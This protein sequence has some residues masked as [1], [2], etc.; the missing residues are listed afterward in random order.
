MRHINTGQLETR[1]YFQMLALE[2][3]TFSGTG[4]VKVIHS[5]AHRFK[6]TK[7]A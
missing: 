5:D 2:N 1:K 7:R 6:V 3:N 4:L